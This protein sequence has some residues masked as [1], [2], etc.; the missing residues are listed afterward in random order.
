MNS[1]I[2]ASSTDSVGVVD[3]VGI[4]LPLR[5][6]VVVD[7]GEPPGHDCDIE[8]HEFPFR[9]SF[10]VFRAK[11][12]CHLGSDDGGEVVEGAGVDGSDD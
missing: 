2:L 8:G 6:G 3:V 7:G 10:I 12:H 1:S 9:E 5:D 4:F 11:I